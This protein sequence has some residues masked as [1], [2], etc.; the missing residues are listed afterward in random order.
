MSDFTKAELQ[1]AVQEASEQATKN[2]LK[3]MGFD[4]SQPLQVQQDQ[5]YLRRQR[6]S[7]EAVAVWVKRGVIMTALSGVATMVWL[8][9]QQAIKG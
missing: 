9:I 5:A 7:S 6:E 4:T 8:G 3:S 1:Q 2:I